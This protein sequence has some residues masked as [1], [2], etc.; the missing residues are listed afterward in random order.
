MSD[1]PQIATVTLNAALDQTAQV[2]NFRAGEVNRVESDQSD[3]GGKGVNVASFL[4]QFGH[5]VAAT[6]LLGQSNVQPFEKL[7]GDKG[8]IDR[9]VK[10]PGQ[11]RVNVKIVDP[12]QNSVTDI[13]F[14]GLR[15]GNRDVEAV[16]AAIDGLA[17]DGVER[18]VL[19]GSLPRGMST[20]IYRL[21]IE[22]LKARGRSVILDTS[23][24]P[25]DRALAA[26]PDV[27]KPNIDELQE[28][29]RTELHGHTGIVAAARSLSAGRIGLVVVS[30]G[31]RGALFVTS[32]RAILAVP[33]KAVVKSTVG[34]GDAMVAG[35]AHGQMTGLSLPETAR[36]AT[37]FS[38][39]ALG[40]I[41]P[42]L[43]PRAEIEAFAAQVTITELNAK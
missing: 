26:G 1:F 32:D 21:L 12:Q 25:L 28:L 36:I 24:I 30:M 27:I 42:Y 22:R 17:A 4:A 10:V 2:A 34:A 18:F 35:I 43:P 16:S 31:A 37:G 7:F 13:N 39:G 14:P 20:D 8:I 5:P 9:F 33:P 11:T 19:A 40:Q 23:G 41:G 15:A 38:L 29:T 3:A 6:G